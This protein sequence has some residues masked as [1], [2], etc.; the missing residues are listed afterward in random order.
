M[1]DYERDVQTHQIARHYITLFNKAL[2][3]F[4]ALVNQVQMVPVVHLRIL[5][6]Q[7]EIIDYVNAEP[8]ING[9]FDKITNNNDKVDPRL[10]SDLLMAFMHFTYD[11]SNGNLMVTDLQGWVHADR[12]QA[13]ILTDP[14]INSI[15]GNRFGI[16]NIG[17]RGLQG[18]WDKQ[19]VRC[20]DICRLLDLPKS[21]PNQ[22]VVSPVLTRGDTL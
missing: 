22:D 5:N 21:R 19:H 12:S 17:Q 7:G 11:R 20:N 3:S 16:T 8:Y 4:P 14:A 18:F 1:E 9:S 10:N 15:E 6:D 2:E 13:V